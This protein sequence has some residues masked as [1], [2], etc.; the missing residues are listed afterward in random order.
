VISIFFILVS[1]L[2]FVLHTLS[3]FRITEIDFVNVYINKTATDRTPTL[4][5]QQV[6]PT[7][8]I[9]EWICMFRI[10]FLI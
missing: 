6:H 1:I 10:C 5:R 7:F 9:V 8:D 4:N 2:S 3:M